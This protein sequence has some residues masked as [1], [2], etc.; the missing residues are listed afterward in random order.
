MLGF[1]P[2]E[3]EER[4]STLEE[5][6]VAAGGEAP[7]ARVRNRNTFPFCFVC[8]PFLPQFSSS[9]DGGLVGYLEELLLSV[10]GKMDAGYLLNDMHNVWCIGKMLYQILSSIMYLVPNI[11]ADGKLLK[12][13]AKALKHL[14]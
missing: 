7:R 11:A 9:N 3:D 10:I 1:F 6:V 12:L 4:G 13:I 14:L 5:R 8:I 2:E